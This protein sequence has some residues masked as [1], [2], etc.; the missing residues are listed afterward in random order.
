MVFNKIKIRFNKPLTDDIF[1]LRLESPE[2]AKAAKPG[3]FVN[4]YMNDKAHMLPRPISIC[5]INDGEIRVVYRRVGEGTG[6]LSEMK[7]GEFVDVMGP[8]GNGYDTDHINEHFSHVLLFGGGV[9]IPPMLEL[10]KRLKVPADVFLGYRDVLFLHED[11]P[12][13]VNV[14]ISTEDGSAGTKGNVLDAL[15]EQGVAGDCICACGPGPMLRA[16]RAYSEENN[17]KAYFSL[18]ERMACGV[19][20][21][22]GCVCKTRGVDEHS[23]V[24]NARVCLDGPVFEVDLLEYDR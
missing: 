15:Q 3:Q 1:D 9:G 10:A 18:E 2:I 7:A 24:K 5:E 22:L 19:G 21:C 8:V 6:L 14:H 12:A 20:A 4:I 17:I 23:Q 13:N 11:F 16:I